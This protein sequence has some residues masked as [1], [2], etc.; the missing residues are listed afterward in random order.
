MSQV[1]TPQHEGHTPAL[2]GGAR[3]YTKGKKSRLTGF[4]FVTLVTFV[5][6]KFFR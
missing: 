2:A 3:E 5:F 4:P 6:E 1:K